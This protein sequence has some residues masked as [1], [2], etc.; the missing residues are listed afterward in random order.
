MPPRGITPRLLTRALT[1]LLPPAQA[2]L[3]SA[4]QMQ[5]ALSYL[6]MQQQQMQ[7]LQVCEQHPDA[8]HGKPRPPFVLACSAA[9]L[10]PRTYTGAVHKQTD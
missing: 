10:E 2:K 4:G 8:D 6:Q 5:T 7:A 1:P 3:Q 9:T